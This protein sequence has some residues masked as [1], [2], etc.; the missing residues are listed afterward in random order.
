MYY[1]GARSCVRCLLQLL[2]ILLII[3]IIIS[4]KI[5]LY[6]CVLVIIRIYVSIMPIELRSSGARV[7]GDD[8]SHP[9][10]MLRTE[11]GHWDRSALNQ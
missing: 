9:K 1:V 2:S 5:Q 11:L 10:R 7:V 8:E 6:V 4:L 3:I